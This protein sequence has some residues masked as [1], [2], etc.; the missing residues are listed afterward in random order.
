LVKNTKIVHT[1]ICKNKLWRVRVTA[2]TN[3]GSKFLMTNGEAITKAIA[4]AWSDEAYKARLFSNTRAA[5]AELDIKMPEDLNFRVIEEKSSDTL[6]FIL[7]Q[8]PDE[9]KKLSQN[10]LENA[11]KETMMYLNPENS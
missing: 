3:E 1:N 9:P 6:T 11:A 4:R 8:A 5:L 7:P 10:D 2:S